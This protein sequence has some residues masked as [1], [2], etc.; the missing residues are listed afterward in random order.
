MTCAEEPRSRNGVSL[1]DNPSYG[2]R[3]GRT[4]I[5]DIA[6]RHRRV[7]FVPDS[8]IGKTIR[9]PRHRAFIGTDLFFASRPDLNFSAHTP[10]RYFCTNGALTFI[11]RPL[12]L[13]AACTTRARGVS[14][15]KPLSVIG[16]MFVAAIFATVPIS[17]QVTPRGIELSVDQAQAQVTYGQ[18]RR[19]ARRA[20]RRADRY[21]RRA[22]YGVAAGGA[23]LAASGGP[24]SLGVV[25]APGRSATVIDPATGRRCT[26]EPSGWH[27]CWKP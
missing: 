7:R 11:T 3:P 10:G 12:T 1:R 23:Y 19:V 13:L 27:W 26:I 6:R 25:V 16:L 15:M 24:R 9:S 22:G 17:P 21:D 5:A 4:P 18:A 2:S 8:D 20:D 14:V